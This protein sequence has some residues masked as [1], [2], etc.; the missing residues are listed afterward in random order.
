VE[1]FRVFPLSGSAGLEI[2]PTLAGKPPVAPG[3]PVLGI[4]KDPVG[5]LGTLVASAGRLYAAGTVS[6]RPVIGVMGGANVDA[7]AVQTAR[8]LGALVADRGWILLN[9]GRDAGVMAAS[10]EGAKNAGGTVVGILPGSDRAGACPNLDMAIVTGMG[11]ARN[12]INVLSSDV[13]I[14]CA[15]GAGTLSEVGLALKNGKRVIL[16]GFDGGPV[17]DGFRPSGLLTSATSPEEAVSQAA[18][19]LTAMAL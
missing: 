17:L 11:D 12:V 18:A 9:G 2:A 3:R 7:A 6:R 1:P 4:L 19:A 13:V 8:R 15:G 10:A 14:A 5:V 16:L